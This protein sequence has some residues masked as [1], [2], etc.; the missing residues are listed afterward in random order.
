MIYRYRDFVPEIAEDAFV[1]PDAQIIGRVKIASGCS[2]WF[3]CQV[4]GDVHYIEIGENTNVQDGST[5]HVTREKYP[6]IIGKNCT[7]GHAAKAHGAI[8]HDYAFM[9][10]GSI[11][12]D[13]S[14][15]GEFGLL[16]A[17]SLLP[18][19]KKIPPR[20]VAMGVPAKVIREITPEEERMILQ[21]PLNYHAHSVE[22]RNKEVFERLDS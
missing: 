10:I 16:A 18:P 9:A 5:L 21:T 14:E 1:A 17:G 3:G 6:L 11:A 12:L 13:G 7:L 20:M 4:R 2:I 15:I 22:Y 8:L 19:G